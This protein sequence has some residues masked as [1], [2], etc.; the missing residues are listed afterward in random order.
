M[1]YDYLCDSHKELLDLIKIGIKTVIVL[2]SPLVLLGFLVM[3][4]P[5]S[6]TTSIGQHERLQWSTKVVQVIQVWGVWGYPFGHDPKWSMRF[7]VLQQI[8]KNCVQQTR[9][10]R[11]KLKETQLLARSAERTNIQ[12]LGVEAHLSL[13][14][15]RGSFALPA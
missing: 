5:W 4:L 11:D 14:P 6:L 7:T 1:K 10:K 8:Q 15:F 13:L 9:D 2:L 3:T 12:D